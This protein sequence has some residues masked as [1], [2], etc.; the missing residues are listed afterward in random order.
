VIFHFRGASHL[1]IQSTLSTF[2]FTKPIQEQ[3]SFRK[4]SS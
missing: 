3:Q 1:T 4:E 2:A